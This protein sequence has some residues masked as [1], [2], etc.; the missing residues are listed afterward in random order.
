MSKIHVYFM[1]GLAASSAIFEKIELPEAIFEIHLLEWILPVA[2]ESIQSYAKRMAQ[3][4]HHQEVV[5]I[6]VSFGGILVQEMA[7]FL[8]VKKVIII[9]SVKSSEELPMRMKFAKATKIY[10]LIP[11][12]LLKN[13]NFLLKFAFGTQLKNRL[14]LYQRFVYMND[15]RYLNWA[16]EQVICWDRKQIDPKVVHIHGDADAIFPMKYIKNAVCV[17]KGT[18]LM[19]INRHKW[20]NE[21]LP[22]L[23][24][25]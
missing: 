3:L 24:V 5:L 23:I 15:V 9:S 13:V 11:T 7:A 12:R 20:F 4:V 25:K 16:I 18:H 8:Q 19:I 6:G 1:P 22:N 14:E 17:S 10:K 2:N 21:F